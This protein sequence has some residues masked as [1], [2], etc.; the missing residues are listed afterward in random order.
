M[1]PIERAP[2]LCVLLLA[3]VGACGD[4]PAATSLGMPTSSET[5]SSD[6]TTATSTSDASTN[7]TS[8]DTDD[9]STTLE[10]C[11]DGGNLPPDDETE[12]ALNQGQGPPVVL[13]RPLPIPQDLGSGTS[14]CDEFA[15]D[16]PE[17]EKCVPHA[18]TG[19]AWDATCVPVLGDG[20]IGE[21]C[22]YAGPIEATDDCDASS[23]CWLVDEQGMGTCT[24]FCGGSAQAPECPL[25]QYCLQLDGAVAF[26]VDGCNPLEQACPEGQACVWTGETFACTLTAAKFPA[27]EPCGDF[28]DCG[29]SMICVDAASLPSCGGASCCAEFCDL[30]CPDLCSQVG[31][32][33]VPFFAMGEAP[34]GEG[35]I[36]VCV[37]P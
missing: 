27:G 16:C 2:W 33:C 21:P 29:I 24:G 25:D 19:G 23:A 18:S 30:D 6:G 17:G 7:E 20:M 34:P 13:P 35:D 9:S 14:E 10:G 28:D 4:K 3:A 36:G 1:R 12:V 31:T 26:C 8:S 37:A 15:Q 11:V 32:S 5:G 22:T